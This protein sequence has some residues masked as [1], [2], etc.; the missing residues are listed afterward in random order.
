[1]FKAYFVYRGDRLIGAIEVTSATARRL[2][3][4]GYRLQPTRSPKY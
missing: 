3:S 2:E 4:K 1:M